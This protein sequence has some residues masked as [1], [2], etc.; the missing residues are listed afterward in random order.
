M[1]FTLTRLSALP[2][3]KLKGCFANIPYLNCMYPCG[4][5]KIESLNHLLVFCHQLATP[6]SFWINPILCK[7]L[8][9]L[10]SWVIALISADSIALMF[11]HSNPEIMYAV[12]RFLTII[13]SSNVFA[14]H[15]ILVARK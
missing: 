11:A 2:T 4:S 10:K 9:H 7:Y 6:R 3:V 12:A 15:F 5:S 13:I 8:Y 14:R 1:C